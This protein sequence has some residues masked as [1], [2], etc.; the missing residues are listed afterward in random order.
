VNHGSILLPLLKNESINKHKW[1]AQN[2]DFQG[3]FDY[4]D[5]TSHN[6]KY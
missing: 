3:I 6:E 1:G 5:K 4:M 2:N